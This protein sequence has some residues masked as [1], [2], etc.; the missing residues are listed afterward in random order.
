[1]DCHRIFKSLFSISLA[2]SSLLL[3]AQFVVA[4]T[5]LENE[6]F[7]WFSTAEE[8]A[9]A[10]VVYSTARKAVDP[11]IELGICTYGK[12]LNDGLQTM[13]EIAGDHVDFLADR[14]VD[15]ANLDRKIGIIRDWNRRHGTE[16]RYANT[17]YFVPPFDRVTA[18][19]VEKLGE[20]SSRNLPNATWG[21]G[22]SWANLLMQW[23]R[24][25]GDVV[26]A[27]Y[28]SFVNDHFHSV[29][30]TP[31]EGAFL[32]YPA[33]VG[34]LFRE[35]K[36][37]WLLKLD[38]YEPD[39]RQ[40]LQAQVAWNGEKTELVVYLYNAHAEERQLTFDLSAMSKRF[41]HARATYLI[42][43]TL[44]T[45]RSVKNDSPMVVPETSERR[46][47]LDGGRWN[48]IV[49]AHSFAEIEL[50]EKHHH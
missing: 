19:S 12:H 20:Q 30:D 16:I 40:P 25:G 23:Q 29:I 50:S 4:Q 7:R 44:N 21:Y 18:E 8:Y 39:V 27:A 37:R 2:A 9:N 43:P 22:L 45:V 13:L 11:S 15:Q 33:A 41:N 28:N 14:G 5:E 34:S 17:E 32:R 38:G 49:P 36:A 3:T 10:C 6:A 1:M 46:F 31:K 42:G 47:S 26:F 48:T 24:Y 35:S